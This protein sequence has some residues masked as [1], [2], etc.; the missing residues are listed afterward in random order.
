MVAAY[1]VAAKASLTVVRSPEDASTQGR[2]IFLTRFPFIIGR[3]EG[4]LLIQDANLSRRHAKITF[5]GASGIYF[6]TDLNSSNGTR[7]N[8]VPI[9]PGQAKQLTSGD[10]LSLG[11]NALM[12]F[13]LV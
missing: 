10:S 3:V 8:G 13:D 7:L 4:S 12:R 9:V 5:D 11:P 6:I 1:P 2:Q